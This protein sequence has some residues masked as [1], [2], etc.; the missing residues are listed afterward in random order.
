MAVDTSLIPLGSRVFIRAYCGTVGKGWAIAGDTGSAIT[1]RHIDM[2]R[3]PPESADDQGQRLDD[4]RILVIPPG[5][6]APRRMP[7]C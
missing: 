1:G 7:R 2:Y 4:Q 6:R 5:A 3:R